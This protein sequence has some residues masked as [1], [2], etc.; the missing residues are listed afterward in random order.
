MGVAEFEIIKLKINGPQAS[1]T[2][3]VIYS[4]IDSQIGKNFEI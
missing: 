3:T 2:M 4:S 1:F